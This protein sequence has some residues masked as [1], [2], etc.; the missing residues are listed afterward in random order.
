[1]SVQGGSV[2]VGNAIS[3]TPTAGQTDFVVSSASDN[4]RFLFGQS[5]TAYGG[6]DWRYNAVVA[7]AYLQIGVR[8]A[9]ATLTGISINNL[10]NVG[11]GTT[12]PT[13]RLHLKAGTA[14]A[15]TAPLKFASGVSLTTP[16]AGAVEFDGTDFFLTPSTVRWKIARLPNS[17][18]PAYTVTNALTDRTFDA[19]ATSLDELADVLGSLIADLKLTNIIA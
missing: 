5:N 6:M 8:T 9:P 12:G 19:N 10:G 17:A 2:Q 4:S 18:A 14:T 7:N 3:Y 16:E 11:I 15:A 13:A 1:L